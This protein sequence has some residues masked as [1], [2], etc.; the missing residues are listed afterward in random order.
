MN[1]EEQIGALEQIDAALANGKPGGIHELHKFLVDSELKLLL[2]MNPD[3]GLPAPDG[4]D[5]EFGAMLWLLRNSGEEFERLLEQEKWVQLAYGILMHELPASNGDDVFSHFKDDSYVASDGTLYGVEK[6]EQLDPLWLL[7]LLNYVVNL[8]FP[9]SVVHP[10]PGFTEQGVTPIQPV[11]LTSKV[12]GNGKE[13]LSI[14]ILGDWGAGFYSESF[15]GAEVAC[16]AKRVTQDLVTHS[17]DYLIH[18]GDVYYA[19]TDGRPPAHEEQKNFLDVWPDQGEGRNFTINSNH[20]MYGAAHGFFNVALASENCSYFK[21]QK[22]FSVFALT[23]GN[24]LLLGLDSA[25]FSDKANGLH[26]Y[27]EGA[28]SAPNSQADDRF[29]QLDMVKKICAEHSGPVMVM[30]HHNPCDTV[31]A[32]TNLLY[33]QLVG[34]LGREPTLWY[35]GHVHNAIVYNKLNHGPGNFAGALGRCCGHGAVPFGKAWGLEA[36]D[37]KSN[38][39]YFVTNHDDALP[40]DNPRVKNGYAIINLKNDGFTESFYEVGDPNNP[41]YTKT[42]TI[43]PATNLAVV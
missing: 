28:L 4:G 2:E 11:A 27:M 25:Y 33:T 19:G 38:I 9:E 37:V 21:A 34:L 29:A 13:G 7:S 36:P 8:L 20:E 16:P 10:F 40:T 15:G 1:L 14:G 3:S 42:W 31:T 41:A 22:G 32:K 5:A 39:A 24:W 26:M 43:D 35:W 30:T 12:P 23:Y 6:Y 17:M 18:L